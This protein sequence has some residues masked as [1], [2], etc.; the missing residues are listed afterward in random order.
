MKRYSLFKKHTVKSG[1]KIPGEQKYFVDPESGS[2]SIEKSEPVQKG[3]DCVERF[4][5]NNG[6]AIMF[7]NPLFRFIL[8]K[9]T[10]I[11]L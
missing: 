2:G 6:L 1:T 3:L 7:M 8:I 9:L 10:Y 5:I 4:T 11:G